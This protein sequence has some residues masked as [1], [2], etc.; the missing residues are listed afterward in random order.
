[1]GKVL[2]PY[3]MRAGLRLAS[4][5]KVILPL[6][7]PAWPHSTSPG[8]K[9]TAADMGEVTA[10]ATPVN[11]VTAHSPDL[12]VQTDPES[13]TETLVIR[14]A[15]DCLHSPHRLSRG[16]ELRVCMCLQRL[17]WFAPI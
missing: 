6:S 13:H 2:V 8:S 14:Y 9:V 10:S 15:Q 7:E 5:C 4:S 3:A 12:G 11:T 1:M 17:L 16:E